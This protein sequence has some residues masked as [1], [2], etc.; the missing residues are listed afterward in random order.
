MNYG[1][2]EKYPENERWELIDG[3]PYLQGQPSPLHQSCVIQL[4]IQ[5]GNFLKDKPCEILH[6]TSVWL[7]LKPGQKPKN[8]SRYVVPDL[9]VICDK[10]KIQDDGIYGVPDLVIEVLSPSTA[11]VDAVKKYNQYLSVGLGE[12]WI[13][14]PLNAL[15]TVFTIKNDDYK[16]KIYAKK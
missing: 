10:T 15:I 2:I 16:S 11:G 7:D 13:V 3:I 6:E 8:S 1:D 4:I 5:F 14:D 9:L 12:Y